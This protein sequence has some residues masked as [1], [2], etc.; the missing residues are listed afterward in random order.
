MS[1]E[2][3]AIKNAWE[4]TIR[5]VLHAF[6][7]SDIDHLANY[8]FIVIEQHDDG[9]LDLNPLDNRISQLTGV[10]IKYGVPGITAK[11]QQGSRCYVTW[12]GA[13][14]EKP[15]VVG[16]APGT[17]LE[18]IVAK[19][20]EGVA[21]VDDTVDTDTTMKIWIQKVTVLL[22]GSPTAPAPII[23]DPTLLAPLDFGKISSGSDVVKVG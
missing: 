20:S 7:I 17:I 9:T 18:L 1:E 10:P 13:N 23:S 14:P 8:E 6:I 2:V 11:V 21:R 19:G 4:R 15:I 16:W 12:E 22:A 5:R 3:N